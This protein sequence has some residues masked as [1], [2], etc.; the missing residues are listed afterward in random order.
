MSEHGPRPK[1]ERNAEIVRLRVKDK[2]PYSAIGKTL[3]ISTQRV[4]FIV[5]RELKEAGKD[6]V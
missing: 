3:G 2:L 5:K 1:I 4:H 6:R